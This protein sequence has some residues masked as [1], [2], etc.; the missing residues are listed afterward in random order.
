M[1][2]LAELQGSGLHLLLATCTI[3]FADRRDPVEWKE[4]PSIIERFDVSPIAAA[5]S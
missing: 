5:K 4:W 3:N 2:L 1:D